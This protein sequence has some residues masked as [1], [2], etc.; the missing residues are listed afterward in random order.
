VRGKR[1]RY[2][3]PVSVF[4]LTSAVSL[5]LHARKADELR[6]LLREGMGSF[7]FFS[8]AQKARY[9]E[10][11]MASIELSYAY[12]VIVFVVT[13]ALS[14]RLF[15]RRSGFTFTELLVPALYGVAVY[16]LCNAAVMGLDLLGL[17][18]IPSEVEILLGYLVGPIL[19]AWVAAGF[20]PGRRW[21]SSLKGAFG[22]VAAFLLFA[23]L[24]DGTLVAYVLL[25]VPG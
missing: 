4:L 19:F 25:T 7:A 20:F 1:Q 23:L 14:W 22:F 15:F 6:R 11:V 13:I 18:S 12:Q 5:F 10:V 17:M 21:V 24:R 8:P 2:T 3:N 16:Q 9:P